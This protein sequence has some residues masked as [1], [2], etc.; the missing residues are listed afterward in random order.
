VFL[1]KR[2]QILKIWY[3]TSKIFFK[4]RNL[5]LWANPFQL[6]DCKKQKSNF[7]RK[8]FL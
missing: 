6:Y 5:Y 2:R 1:K 4:A 8:N 3:S 7:T